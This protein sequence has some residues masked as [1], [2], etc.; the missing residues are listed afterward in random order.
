MSSFKDFSRYISDNAESL[1]A[2]VV[3]SVVQ[4]MNLNI[5]EWEKERAAGMYIQLLEFFGQALLES[6][7]IE[8][9]DAL[10]EWSKKMRKC[11]SLRMGLFQ[12][13]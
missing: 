11:K 2:E 6:G 12:R 9:P 4:E 10:I 1:S 13:L 3:E 8:V 5:P 7:Q